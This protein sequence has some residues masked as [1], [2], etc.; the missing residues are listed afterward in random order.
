MPHPI[1]RFAIMPFAGRYRLHIETEDGE[2]VELRA[3]F[4]QLDLL[5]EDIDRRLDADQDT[6]N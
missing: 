5:A 6:S 4:N 3:S 1:K 2:A